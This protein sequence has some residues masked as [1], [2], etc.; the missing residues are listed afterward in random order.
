MILPS[1]GGAERRFIGEKT[2]C[3][4]IQHLDV[5]LWYAIGLR[6]LKDVIELG[7]VLRHTETIWQRCTETISLDGVKRYC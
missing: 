5:V 1:A 7:K 2:G 3:K 4:A 6:G